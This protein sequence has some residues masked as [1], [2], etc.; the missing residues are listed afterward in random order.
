MY[1]EKTGQAFMTNNQKKTERK[2]VSKM[3]VDSFVKSSGEEKGFQKIDVQSVFFEKGKEIADKLKEFGY[4]EM[5][6]FI[7]GEKV[8]T[9][10]MNFAQCCKKGESHIRVIPAKDGT[11]SFIR[12]GRDADAGGKGNPEYKYYLIKTDEKGSIKKEIF[13]QQFRDYKSLD[14]KG[15]PDGRAVLI[16]DEKFTSFSPDGKEIWSNIRLDSNSQYK[17]KFS[18]DGTIFIMDFDSKILRKN[19]II[20]AVNPDG[21]IRWKKRVSS[22]MMDTDEKG[23]LYVH[24]FENSYKIIHPDGTEEKPVV[25]PDNMR[26]ESLKIE[27]NGRVIALCGSLSPDMSMGPGMYNYYEGKS[28]AIYDKF[29]VLNSWS[30]GNNEQGNEVKSFSI[31]EGNATDL[32]VGDAGSFYVINNKAVLEDQIVSYAPDGK[33][34]WQIDLPQKSNS[35]DRPHVNVGKDG[36]IYLS[37]NEVDDSSDVPDS[38]KEAFPPD[39]KK[40]G[41]FNFKGV[42][43]LI[44]CIS[45]DGKVLYQQK[46]EEDKFEKNKPAFL[47]NGDVVFVSD[48]DKVHLISRDPGKARKIISGEMEGIYQ[49]KIEE[50][51]ELAIKVDRKKKVVDIGGVKLPIK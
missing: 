17:I 32:A 43:S 1:I 18:P 38:Y 6:D 27:K 40:K 4:S 15:D 13:L 29:S 14:I 20:S 9:F 37:I 34:K 21:S 31:V 50:E 28:I 41:H 49:E 33:I 42:K 12:V 19:N 10:K 23:N 51:E 48:K 25:F 11:F 39:C 8:A 2:S 44:V 22:R 5:S 16:T 26:I 45:P 7:T 3:P 36:N 46:V 47:E 30:S 35:R 24:D